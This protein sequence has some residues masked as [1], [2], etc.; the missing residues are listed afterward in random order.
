MIVSLFSLI[1]ARG[2]EVPVVDPRLTSHIEYASRVDTPDQGPATLA[3]STDD[4]SALDAQPASTSTS[5]STDAVAPK[6]EA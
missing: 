2:A 4:A 6:G 1:V 5:S 3:D